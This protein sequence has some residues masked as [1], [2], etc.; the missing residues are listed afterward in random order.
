MPARV[1]RTTVLVITVTA[2]V[3]VVALAV[4]QLARGALGPEPAVAAAETSAPETAAPAT[5]AAVATPEAVAGVAVLRE[6]DEARA[7]AWAAGDEH[8]LRE[9]YVPGSRAG[10]EDVAMLRRWVAR[11]LRV[12]GMQTQVL[13]VDLLERSESRLVLRVTDRLAGAVAVR[14]SDGDE[15]SLPRDRASTQ[16]MVFRRTP[17]GWLLASVRA[18]AR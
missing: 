11:G 1:D 15:W 10:E 4:T 16:R 3:A 13:S 17:E 7:A 2:F 6:W 9:L 8:A 18:V 5:T 12:E 14:D